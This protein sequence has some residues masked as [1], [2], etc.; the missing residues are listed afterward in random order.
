M[1]E[2]RP[3]VPESEDCTPSTISLASD[4]V[5][6]ALRCLGVTR[7]E[8]TW[9]DVADSYRALSQKWLYGQRSPE[10]SVQLAIAYAA[11]RF[12]ESALEPVLRDGQR[13]LELASE[14]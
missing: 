10:V 14:L 13:V 9:D 1:T 4:R 2:M 6:E 5:R 12:L 3:P 8:P 7:V 11:Y